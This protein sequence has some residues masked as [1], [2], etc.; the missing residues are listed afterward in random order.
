MIDFLQDVFAANTDRDAIVWHDQVFSYGWLADRLR[1]WIDRLQFE[2]VSPGSVVALE[3][4]FTPNSIAL[5][6]A[7]TEQR[8][9]VVPLTASVSASRDDF[10]GIAQVEVSICIDDDDSVRIDRLAV[11]AEHPLYSELR[12]SDHPGLVIFS[13][14]STGQSKAAV[15]DLVKILDKF[16]TPRH[17]LR[18]ISFLLFDHIGGLNTMFYQLSNAGCMVTLTDRLPDSVLTAISAHRVE[19]LP[20][21]PTFL[22]LML[23]SGAIKRHDLSSLQTVTYGTEPMSESTLKLLHESLPGVRLL[24]TYGLSEL[25]IL[26]SKSLSSDSLWVKIG[27]EGFETRIVDQV[28]HIKAESAMLGYLNVDSPLSVDGWYDT[29]DLVE[30]DGEYI[31][32]LGRESEVINVGGRK[33]YPAEVESVIQEVAGVEDVSVYH[34]ENAFVGNIVCARVSLQQD[35]DSR[36]VVKSIKRF[37][38]ENM[39]RHKVPAKVIVSTE[40]ELGRRFKK[41]RRAHHG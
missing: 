4:D 34:E 40:N 20:A 39:A 28:L 21:S 1:Y 24:Q 7:L 26:R 41:I 2:N 27:G 22:R 33:V 38:R 8:C 19:L 16:R 10:V 18:A 37:C 11:H 5:F 31:R 32:F 17:S 3:A 9:I 25:G 35:T 23:L 30:Q 14:G 36:S 6:L 29:G 13:S 15:H 12:A